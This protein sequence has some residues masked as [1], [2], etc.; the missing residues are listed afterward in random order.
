MVIDP[1]YLELGRLVRAHRTRLQLT[2]E[3]LAERIGLSRTSITNIEKGR[4]KI[5]IHQLFALAEALKIR[6]EALLPTV[7]TDQIPASVE[8]KLAGLKG[9]EREWARRIFVSSSKGGVN[10]ATSKD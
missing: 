10:L 1:L 6:P 4:Q 3:T 7:R 8:Q 9:A 5:L 2:Q